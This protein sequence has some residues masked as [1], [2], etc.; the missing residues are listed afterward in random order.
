MYDNTNGYATAN[1]G[2]NGYVTATIEQLVVKVYT[3]QTDL[4]RL[5]IAESG[6]VY[7]LGIGFIPF[8]V[9]YVTYQKIPTQPLP[10]ILEAYQRLQCKQSLARPNSFLFTVIERV[11]DTMIGLTHLCVTIL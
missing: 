3:V 8:N 7:V 2:T 6:H 10:N 5:P 11:T 9:E 1:S 4:V